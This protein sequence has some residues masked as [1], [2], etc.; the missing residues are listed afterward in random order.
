LDA[1]TQPQVVSRERRPTKPLQNTAR[2]FFELS[3][4]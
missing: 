3:H 1:E 2:M 4:I